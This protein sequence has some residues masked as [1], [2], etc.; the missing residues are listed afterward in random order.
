MKGT[1]GSKLRVLVFLSI[2]ITT[3]WTASLAFGG[4]AS[5]PEATA[6]TA[7]LPYY[8][9]ALDGLLENP[10]LFTQQLNESFA[11]ADQSLQRNLTSEAMCVS[12][13]GG[14][15]VT[16]IEECTKRPN[17][18]VQESPENSGIGI[19][20]TVQ[21]ARRAQRDKPDGALAP[22]ERALERQFGMSGIAAKKYVK[23]THDCD[24]FAFRAFHWLRRFYGD[25]V[26][27]KWYAYTN[28]AGQRVGHALNDIHWEDGTTTYF[29]PQTG[30]V[31]ELPE[32]RNQTFESTDVDEVNER[33]AAETERER[34][35]P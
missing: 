7:Y 9:L 31:V 1:I 32:P 12:P 21:Q 28:A 13:G 16:T 25:T 4:E 29:E 34:R 27:V 5:S 35:Q 23:D 8:D 18:V 26:S 19:G 11:R 20:V 15:A 30:Q 24:D 10:R 33:Q 3:V 6:D 2:V 22:R 17:H 14:V